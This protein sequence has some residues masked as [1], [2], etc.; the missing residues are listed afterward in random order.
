MI[1]VI[2]MKFAA[3]ILAIT[4]CILSNLAFANDE[5]D[6]F[7][8]GGSFGNA[9]FDGN[10]DEDN[11]SGIDFKSD[12]TGYKLFGI[13]R[14]GAFALEGGYIDFGAPTTTSENEELKYEL[15]G[16][17][18]FA[19]GNLTLGPVDLFGKVGLFLW[20]EDQTQGSISVGDKGTDL[21]LCHSL[22]MVTVDRTIPG[23]TVFF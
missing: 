5:S 11:L 23:H 17:D 19:V 21:A 9:T 15:T 10:F 4:L 6:G 14:T 13:L 2:R 16:W 7:Y 22:K 8:L 1:E 18:L 20:N 12:D 3:L